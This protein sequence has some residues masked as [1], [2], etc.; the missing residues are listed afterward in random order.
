MTQGDQ[1]RLY[2]SRT[3][4]SIA[5]VCG[6][7]GEYFDV[8]STL[9]RLIAVA[10]LIVGNVATLIAYLVLAVVVPEEP[11]YTTPSAGPVTP[12]APPG[13]SGATATYGAATGPPPRPTGARPGPEAGSDGPAIP[14]P[15]S[16]DGPAVQ[17]VVPPESGRRGGITVGIVLVAI[18][19]LALAV[20]VL[21]G[22]AWWQMWPL[23]IVAV[24]I[25]ESVTPGSEG[26]SVARLFE[27]LTTMAFGLVL[28]ANA[29]GYISWSV[30]WRYLLPLWP[31]W[32]VAIGLSLLGRG[33]KQ[34]WLRALGSIVI[35]GWL[36]MG[37]F[38]LPARASES[39]GLVLG[40]AASVSSFAEPVGVVT[41]AG[42]ALSADAGDIRVQS[43]GELVEVDSRSPFGEPRLSVVR[44][45]GSAGQEPAE[46]AD[47]QLDLGGVDRV[48]IWPGGMPRTDVRLGREV[49]WTIDVETGAAA[50]DVDVSD[51]EVRG[52]TVDAGVSS[53]AVRLGRA[54]S[55]SPVSGRPSLPAPVLV[56]TAVGDI[57]IQVPAGQP[58]RVEIQGGVTGVNVDGDLDE[59][60]GRVYETADYG[61]SA[62]PARWLIRVEAAV[63]AV[64][65]DTY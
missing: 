54:P 60:A 37:A 26:W 11:A 1:R 6:G 64:T 51:L 29:T 22:I 49:A 27:G 53:T 58:T 32:L 43:G 16:P 4:R 19:V 50:I 42:L 15:P 3:D 21:P 41:E 14:P 7:I 2:R 12:G 46:S 5:G 33:L 52:L 23:I 35:I 8:D 56:K 45:S 34:N 59:V 62:L 40:G 25:G 28:L 18:G 47:V 31:V 57:R 13:S 20:N 30:W 48:V 44:S 17:G 55:S 10:L 38:V 9:V 39:V 63:G 36:V 61:D 65:I 24:G